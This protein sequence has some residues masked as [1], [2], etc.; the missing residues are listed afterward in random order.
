[1]KDAFYI[2]IETMHV[3]DRGDKDNVS[4][5]QLNINYPIQYTFQATSRP[6]LKLVCLPQLCQPIKSPPLKSFY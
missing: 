4:N 3:D 6:K 1:M 2:K 5:N